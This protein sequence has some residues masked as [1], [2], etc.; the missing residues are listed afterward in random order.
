[1]EGFGH[2]PPPSLTPCRA[3]S[4]SQNSAHTFPDTCMCLLVE[5]GPGAGRGV[6]MCVPLPLVNP[7]SWLCGFGLSVVCRPAALAWGFRACPSPPRLSLSHTHETLACLCN[8]MCVVAVCVRE[9]G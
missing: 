5:E 9:G 1:M 2:L 4:P 6:T 7:G 3:P 8:E